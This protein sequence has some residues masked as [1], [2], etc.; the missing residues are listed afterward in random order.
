[1]AAIIRYQLLYQS[2]NRLPG[3][4]GQHSAACCFLGVSEVTD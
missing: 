3:D 1:M 4:D 2:L